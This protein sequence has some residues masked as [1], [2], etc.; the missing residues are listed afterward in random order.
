MIRGDSFFIPGNQQRAAKTGCII[1]FL[2]FLIREK[3]G[4][5]I[6]CNAAALVFDK[7]SKERNIF[8]QKT[9]F[10]TTQDASI[11]LKYFLTI[12]RSWRPNIITY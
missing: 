5:A 7:L 6:G 9:D 3:D 10:R 11:F 1:K 4:T 2:V 8:T 12:F